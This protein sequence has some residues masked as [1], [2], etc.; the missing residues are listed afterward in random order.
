MTPG[1]L[2]CNNKGTELKTLLYLNK[3]SCFV[4]S[5]GFIDQF[6]IILFAIVSD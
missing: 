3:Q 5:I 6:E 1:R 4:L 2:C